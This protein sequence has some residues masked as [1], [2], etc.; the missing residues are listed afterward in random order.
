MRA[1]LSP[2]ALEKRAP[3]TQGALINVSIDR[4]QT[5]AAAAAVVFPAPALCATD[6]PAQAILSLVVALVAVVE[7]SIPAGEARQLDQKVNCNATTP[8]QR[9]KCRAKGHRTRIERIWSIGGIS[10]GVGGGSGR[11]AF[12]CW[13]GLVI[14]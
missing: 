6:K 14:D 2:L 3:S 11:R 5:R 12:C 10:G 7:L 9:A 4:Y 1:P 8:R 13:L